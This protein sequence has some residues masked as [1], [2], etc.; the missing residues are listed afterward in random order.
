MV[1]GRRPVPVVPLARHVVAAATSADVTVVPED[2]ECPE[3]HAHV[4]RMRQQFDAFDASVF[5]A[6]RKQ[7]AKNAAAWPS[8]GAS[9][10]EPVQ[11]KPGDLVLEVVS[12]PVPTLGEAVKGPFKVVEVRGYMV[13][14][15][16][17]AALISDRLRSS[18]ATSATWL[19]IWI[20]LR[21]GLFWHSVSAW[22]WQV[23]L[24]CG[25]NNPCAT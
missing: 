7:F 16:S 10:R 20:V 19:G 9:R 4:Y 14:V 3:P 23:F 15:L 5:N 17:L 12:G 13:V 11:L 1:Y 22:A 2:F 25:G 6:I 24:L 8:R 21:C 18:L